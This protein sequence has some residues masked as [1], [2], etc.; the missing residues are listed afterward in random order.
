LCRI[1]VAV[2]WLNYHH[3]LYFWMVAREGSVA[4]A[5]AQLRLAQPT[6]SGQI[7]TL[8][9]TLD[10]KLF[11]RVGRNL[12][13]T[14]TGHL[15]YRYADEI[16]GVGRELMD[17][18]RGRPTG[19]PV[20]LQVGV[21]DVVPKLIAHRLLAP[22]LALKDPVQVV[23]REDKAD[24]L[25]AELAV[26][27]L[28]LVIS[29]APLAGEARVRAYNHML[30]ETGVTFFAAPDLARRLRPGFPSSLDG[31]PM[32]LPTDNTVLRRSLDNWFDDL[33][34]HPVLVG[35]FEDSALLK[36]FG[37]A[38]EGVF[39]GPTAIEKSIGGQYDVHVIGR[40]EAVKERFYAITVERR[41]KHPAVAAISA[42]AR[43]DLFA[44]T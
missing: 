19:R 15:V 10:V 17:T 4:K 12:A 14:D 36:V 29:D 3:L 7:R 28:D 44:D 41:I 40:T 8:E 39:G 32:L 38:G 21:A 22:A 13:L 35:E 42:A 37:Q 1:E 31:A 16:F 26:R 20:K 9:E 23:C 30:G 24:R 43:G 11:K 25:L 18:L 6:I 27:G 2:E 5:S 34:V 33:G